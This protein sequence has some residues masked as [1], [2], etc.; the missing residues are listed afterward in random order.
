[1][2][3]AKRIR[4]IGESASRMR[5]KL[6]V[7]K[8]KCQGCGKEICSDDDLTDVEYVKTKR[9]SDIFFHTGCMDQVWKHEIC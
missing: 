2:D 5:G 8:V 9:N 6:P 4:A 3:L 1:M 7:R